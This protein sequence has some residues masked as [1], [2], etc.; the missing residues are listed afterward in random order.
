MTTD[1]QSHELHARNRIKVYNPGGPKTEGIFSEPAHKRAGKHERQVTARDRLDRIKNVFCPSD[2]SYERKLR[3]VL[4]FNA[5]VAGLLFGVWLL[6]LWNFQFH[7]DEMRRLDFWFAVAFS[8][9]TPLAFVDVFDDYRR[10]RWYR[11]CIAD[12]KRMRAEGDELEVITKAVRQHAENK[13]SPELAAKY[14]ADLDRLKKQIANDPVKDGVD[15]R[16]A[17]SYREEVDG[18]PLV[19]TT[20]SMIRREDVSVGS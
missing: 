11:W 5:F 2:R 19:I 10:L 3:R 15:T 9:I 7:F 18:T 13:T 16:V 6:M 14:R 1:K 8:A 12:T 4:W 17:I 20:T